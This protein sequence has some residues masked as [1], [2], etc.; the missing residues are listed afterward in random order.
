MSI[1]FRNFESQASAKSTSSKWMKGAEN[2]KTGGCWLEGPG[3]T[4][5][6]GWRLSPGELCLGPL[7][8]RVEWQE[9]IN[10]GSCRD[11]NGVDQHIEP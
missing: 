7:A 6:Y 9:I 4:L 3:S 8:S 2:K 11:S 5:S 10:R 1:L